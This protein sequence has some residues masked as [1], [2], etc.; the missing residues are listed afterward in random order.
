MLHGPC[1]GLCS[2]P[3][4]LTAL[5]TDPGLPSRCPFN[6]TCVCSSPILSPIFIPQGHLLWDMLDTSGP[7]MFFP[8]ILH[9]LQGTQANCHKQVLSRRHSM[10]TSDPTPWWPCDSA[11]GADTRG[12]WALPGGAPSVKQGHSLPSQ[13]FWTGGLCREAASAAGQTGQEV[14]GRSALPSSQAVSQPVVP[15]LHCQPTQPWGQLA[16]VPAMSPPLSLIP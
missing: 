9:F 16:E 2:H 14:P 11:G 1:P 4:L 13:S 7:M 5:H 15:R 3:C 10:H 12:R 6:P 8:F